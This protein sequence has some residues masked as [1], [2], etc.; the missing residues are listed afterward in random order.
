MRLQVQQGTL[1]TLTGSNGTLHTANCVRLP[2]VSSSYES[3]TD[4]SKP[5]RV[6]DART[7]INE[8][9]QTNETVGLLELY[10]GGVKLS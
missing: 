6:I 9:V 4:I 7:P 8:T 5:R 10:G 2:Q 3:Y 1:L